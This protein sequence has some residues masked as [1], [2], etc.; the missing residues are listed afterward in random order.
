MKGFLLIPLFGG[1]LAVV[2][3][4]I[5]LLVC[6]FHRSAQWGTLSLLMPPVALWFA[7]R[8]PEETIKP[9]VLLV[10]GQLIFAVPAW[11]LLMM[12]TGLDSQKASGA[13]PRISSVL[14]SA[15]RSDTVHTWVERR[16]FYLQL[17]GVLIAGL[18]WTWLIARAF[19]ERRAWG[20]S[21]FI[22]PPAA[23]LFACAISSSRSGATVASWFGNPPYRSACN[24][25]VVRAFGSRA[26]RQD[27]RWGAH[28]TLTGWDRSDY[29]ILSLAKDVSILQMANP[30]VTDEV[31]GKL[32]EMKTLRELDL[33]GTQVT[34]TG[35]KV[36]RQLPVLESLRLARTKIT[37]AGFRQMLSTKESLM[38]LDVRNTQVSRES[39]KA[40]RDAAPGRKVLR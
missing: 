20:W 22:L 31:V 27:R 7:L 40:W 36:L 29:S 8:H 25:H 39:I 1:S 17:G 35:L 26:A 28:L 30:D 32:Q 4:W 18:A 21:S 2:G 13:E 37:D 15:L 9:L 23:L 3:A 12:P 34:D 38:E 16:A 11:Y 19:Q 24:L 10:M 5:W 33:N 6:A 14:N